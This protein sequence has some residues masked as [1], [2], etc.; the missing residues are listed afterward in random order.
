[1][2]FDGVLKKMHSEV[3]ESGDVR[4]HFAA[5]NSPEMVS[6]NESLGKKIS[7]K[8]Q[9]IMSCSACGKHSKKLFQQ[10]FCFGCSQ[11]RP[12]ADICQVRPELC[13][14]ARG[15]CRDSEWGKSHCFIPHT[16]YLALSSGLKVGITRTRHRLSRWVDQGAVSAVPVGQVSSRFEAGKVEVALKALFSDKT[17]WRAMLKNEVEDANLAR[18]R[19]KA[20]G[21]LPSSVELISD[22]LKKPVCFQYPVLEYPTK[23]ISLNFDKNPDIEGVLLGIKGQYLILDSG[24]LNIRKFSGYHVA[25]HQS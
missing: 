22:S 9:G 4:Y 19:L 6:V 21:S 23:V 13:H 3:S 5:Q 12:E 20:L 11:K 25:I 24:V 17:N 8:Y 16:I 18:A 10:G 14:F 15:T 2:I 7:L 1:M